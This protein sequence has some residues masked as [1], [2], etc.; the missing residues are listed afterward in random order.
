MTATLLLTTWVGGFPCRG[1]GAPQRALPEL[2]R[3]VRSASRLAS[4]DCDRGV[5]ED[6]GPMSAARPGNAA[7]SFGSIAWSREDTPVSRDVT[8]GRHHATSTHAAN[9]FAHAVVQPR[10]P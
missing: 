5:R 10:S 6:A 4:Q 8:H 3:V 1:P 2:S 9:G 7:G